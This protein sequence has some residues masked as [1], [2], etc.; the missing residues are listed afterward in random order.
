MTTVGFDFGT[1]NSLMSVV[2]TAD[3]RERV[4]DVLADDGLPYPSVV[5]YEGEETL[6]GRQAREL[7][8][9]QSVGVHGNVVRSP[10]FLLGRRAVEVGGIERDPIDIVADVVRFVRQE[11]L[12]SGHRAAL[13]GAE[14]AVVTIP[15]TMNGPRRADLREAAG[16]AGITVE[17]FVHEP[18]AA[19]YGYL[20]E[21][22]DTAVM[23]REL[24]G[25]Y[26]LVVDW[27]GG[28][29][30]LTLCR[31]DEHQIVQ[32]RNGGTDE[33]G[34]D[35][36]D[37]AILDEVVART[38]LRDGL[39]ANDE[40]PSAARPG[41]LSRVERA[42]IALSD[43]DEATLFVPRAFPTSGKSLNYRLSR[44]ELD[45]ITKPLVDHGI[46][47]VE[48][49]LDSLGVVPAEIS[50]CLVVGG[51]AAM[52]VIRGR[53][54]ELFGPSRVVVP[55]NAGT[56]ISQGAAWIAHDDQR[57]TLAKRVELEM[58]RGSRMTVLR[59]GTPM[60]AAGEELHRDESLY[61]SD[62]TN[63]TAKLPIVQP[64]AVTDHPQASDPRSTV[65]VLS[66]GVDRMAPPLVERLTIDLVIDDDL[67]LTATASS[68]GTLQSGADRTAES[69]H[70]LEFGIG[71]PGLG[72]ATA[73]D[74]N[75]SGRD[76]RRH[77]K[78]L[79]LNANVVARRDQAAVP[80]DVLYRHRRGAFARLAFPENRATERQLLEHLYYQPCAVCRRP[81]GDPECL[82]AHGT[83]KVA[84]P[85]QTG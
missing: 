40:P 27:G 61:C 30:D 48:A 63:G 17:Q 8:D 75:D 36:F 6:V 76:R 80:G 24:R 83:R 60:P 20:R 23:L 78:G 57:L 42:K 54:Y 43:R 3:G 74:V 69:F 12:H 34:G 10:K 5:R 35:R 72:E 39:G 46:R 49:L 2:V 29:I 50:T 18:L 28:T 11:S 14:R 77:G 58:A 47:L 85:K 22:D 38:M 45:L 67:V 33:I 84:A 62:P 7:L 70:D 15:V 55:S 73:W 13:G 81:W 66:V 1:T 82:C 52:P 53:L 71:F 26:V 59:A 68:H 51:M 9:D 65:G 41:L 56:L 64:V 79:I 16:R 31:I 4:V 21:Q 25:R 32:L 19:L 37:R 44:D